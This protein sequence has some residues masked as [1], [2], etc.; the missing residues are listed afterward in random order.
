[1]N[2]RILN[3]LLFGATLSFTL[4]AEEAAVTWKEDFNDGKKYVVQRVDNDPQKAASYRREY[5][6]G[7]LV[8]YYKFGQ[9]CSKAKDTF[10]YGIAT[11]IDL[12]GGT[13]LEIRYRTPVKGLNNLLTWT[14]TDASGKR[15]GDWKRLPGSEEWNT[16]KIEMHM[17]GFSGQKKNKPE[18]AQL[19]AL[20]IYSSAKN[21]D[22]ERS[23]EIDYICVP[24]K[25]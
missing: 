13:V 25:E 11:P 10:A 5:K 1:M 24:A 6:D 21:D 14:Y 8:L 12:K 18:P 17:D 16:V 2:N 15:A 23:I 20:E 7:T 4:V 19:V 22:V 3:A 9:E